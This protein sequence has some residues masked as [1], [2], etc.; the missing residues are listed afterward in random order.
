[1]STS[2]PNGVA[3]LWPALDRALTQ[4]AIGKI[5]LQEAQRE[6]TQKQTEDYGLK[7]LQNMQRL[8]APM[9]AQQTVGNLTFPE[10]A[11]ARLQESLFPAPPKI[12][13]KNDDQSI[14]SLSSD[15]TS[16]TL[17]PSIPKMVEPKRYTVNGNLV[18]ENGKIVFAA[19][20]EDKPKSIADVFRN[21]FGSGIPE[22]YQPVLGPDGQ[23]TGATKPI[24]GSVADPEVIEQKRV[25]DLQASLPKAQGAFNGALSELD[26][27]IGI[28]DEVLA[29]ESDTGLG[30]VTGF[31][32]TGVGSLFTLPGSDATKVQAKI[33]QLKGRAFLSGLATL[34]AAS[35]N[36]ST[37]L[38]ATSETEGKK[39][40]DAQAALNQAQSAEDFKAALKEYRKALVEAKANIANTFREEFAPAF[41]AGRP[42]QAGASGGWSA[43]EVNP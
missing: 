24:T 41:G 32:G 38:G 26:K 27:T 15:G 16:K 35:P 19:P 4:G 5:G 11:K 37:G 9:P 30:D 40:Q 31:G 25:R 2:G 28:V 29:P 10:V 13:T 6:Q 42:M 20:K 36:G 3:G 23:P 22:N 21:K 14:I 43:V 1:M 7:V 12:M 33:D 8:G 34:K 17:L 39:V 18:D